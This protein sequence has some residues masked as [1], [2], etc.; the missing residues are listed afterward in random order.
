MKL[1]E[2]KDKSG[3]KHIFTYNDTWLNVKDHIKRNSWL[4][5]DLRTVKEIPFPKGRFEASNL[6]STFHAIFYNGEVVVSW[7]DNANVDYP[8]D[9]TWN[10]DISVLISE[11]ERLK[12]LEFKDRLINILKD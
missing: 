7:N 2:L 5:A 12:E 4:D 10:R 3:K 11:V 9:L 8:E 6:D 1:W